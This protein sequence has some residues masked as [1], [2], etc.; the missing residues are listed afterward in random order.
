MATVI[1]AKFGQI[2]KKMK[3]RLISKGV[4]SNERVVI[5]APGR[6]KGPSL[7]YADHY[8]EV[9]PDS[10]LT[11]I[12]I[13]HGAG[14]LDFRVTRKVRI[15]TWTR[16]ELDEPAEDE[17]L[18][19]H[20]DLGHFDHEDDAVDALAGFHPEDESQNALTVGPLHVVTVSAP[21]RPVPEG[22]AMSAFGVEV[23]YE[24]SLDTTE[25]Q[26]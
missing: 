22:W 5:V 17:A 19:T 9:Q 6:H 25:P 18:L 16:L 4:A 13:Y 3:A 8:V 7:E 24:R 12:E 21:D 10:E 23:V 20:E 11:Q 15:I 2:L 1:R 14:R 26:P